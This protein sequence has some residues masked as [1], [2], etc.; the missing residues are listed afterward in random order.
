MKLFVSIILFSIQSWAST[1]YII[2]IP[3]Q[4]PTGSVLIHMGQSCPA[5][6]I[7]ADGSPIPS[8]N[9][10]LAQALGNGS[11]P[12]V[13][14]PDLRGQFLRGVNFPNNSGT[15]QGAMDLN[16]G[17]FTLDS[18]RAAA[19]NQVGT[20]ELDAMQG[21]KHNTG[22]PINPSQGSDFS[23]LT[24]GTSLSS[25]SVEQITSGL[26]ISAGYGDARIAFETRPVNVAVLYCIKL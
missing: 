12:A 13:N 11:V 9:S 4:V 20:V 3:S 17:S 24:G 21:H 18:G 5:G 26:P 23:V 16:G 14:L 15:D 8:A 10:A 7:A 22:F 25:N 19:L 2:G 1:D 6:F